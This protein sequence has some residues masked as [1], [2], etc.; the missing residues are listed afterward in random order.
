MKHIVYHFLVLPIMFLT[1]CGSKT[2]TLSIS[3]PR[4]APMLQAIDASDR[5]ALGFSSI[6]TNAVVHLDSRSSARCDAEIIVYDTPALYGDIYRN[7][8]FRKTATGYQWIRELES[9]PGPKTFTQSGH[10]KHEEIYIAY[11]TTGVMG[12]TP[13]KLHIH[14][15]GPGGQFANGKELTLDQVRPVL[16]EWSQ[17]H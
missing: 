10:T 2:Q 4:L 9:H 7:I 6:R 15:E 17:K 16:A 5:A 1:G 3:D 14:Y 8:E 11:D 12:I 13:N